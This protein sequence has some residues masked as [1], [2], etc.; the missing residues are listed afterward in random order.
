MAATA[1]VRIR[2]KDGESIVPY[3]VYIGRRCTMGGWKL[4]ESVWAN[5]YKVGTHGTREEVIRKYR[6]YLLSKPELLKLLPTM[7]GKRLGCFCAPQPC[8]GDVIAE[9]AE[10]AH[11]QRLEA[12]KKKPPPEPQYVLSDADIDEILG[13]PAARK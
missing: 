11:K 9:L 1:V 3:D 8:H 6:T 12:Q 2:R 13:R 5:P 7:Y 4:P 10:K